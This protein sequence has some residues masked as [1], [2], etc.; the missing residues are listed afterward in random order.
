[1][2]SN[3]ASQYV[4]SRQHCLPKAKERYPFGLSF[5][6]ASL[7]SHVLVVHR[8]L[9]VAQEGPAFLPRA[10]QSGSPGG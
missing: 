1:M 9:P 3:P 5:L 4:M 10:R 2:V 7:T 8:K 6:L